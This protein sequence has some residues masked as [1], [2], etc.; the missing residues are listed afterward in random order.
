[1]RDIACAV[2]APW[3]ADE[4]STVT[5]GYGARTVRI[6]NGIDEREATQIVRELKARHTF[7][8]S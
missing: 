6:A 8:E 1:V 2:S 3:S 7:K 4:G 5:F